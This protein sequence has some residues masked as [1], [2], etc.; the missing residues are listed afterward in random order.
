MVDRNLPPPSRDELQRQARENG[1]SEYE[2]AELAAAGRTL[3]EHYAEERAA[4][5]RAAADL[6]RQENEA[7]RRDERE[8]HLRERGY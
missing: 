2:L 5:L 8:E 7:I 3:A 1:L 4:P 6:Q